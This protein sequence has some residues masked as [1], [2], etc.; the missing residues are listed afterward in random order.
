[1]SINITIQAYITIKNEQIEVMNDFVDLG[2]LISQDSSAKKDIQRRLGLARKKYS[3]LHNMWKSNT[4]SLKTRIH[5]YTPLV[6]PVLLFGAECWQITKCD[7]S[8]VSSFHDHCLR[9]IC[10]IFWPNKISNKKFY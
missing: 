2:S 5:L 7:M 10:R 6:K 9:K 3:R 8:K 4:Y 1:M